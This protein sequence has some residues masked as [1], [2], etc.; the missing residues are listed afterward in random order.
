MILKNRWC[1]YCEGLKLCDNDDLGN[2]YNNSFIN[3]IE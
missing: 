1:P 2:C 3:F